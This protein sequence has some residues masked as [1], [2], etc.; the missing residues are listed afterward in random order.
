MPDNPPLAI[1]F[2]RSHHLARLPENDG[3]AA[4]AAVFA[5]LDKPVIL[6]P[7]KR[8]LISTGL[9]ADMP[10]GFELQVRPR[11]SAAFLD[12]VTVLNAPSGV[13]GRMV[14]ILYV[15][16][17]NHGDDAVTIQNGDRVARVVVAPIVPAVFG[18]IE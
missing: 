14:G 15:L 17:I 7:G 16:L 2:R 4:G 10:E 1:G 8:A 18:W 3:A 5:C 11:P 13:E 9:A 6:H 12:G